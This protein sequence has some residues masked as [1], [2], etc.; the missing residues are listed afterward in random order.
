MTKL[1]DARRSLVRA[2]Q[3][4][5]ERIDKLEEERREIKTTIKSLE[6]ALRALDG[7]NAKSSRPRKSTTD[8]NSNEQAN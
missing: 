8:A 1:A 5:L 3:V 7:S 4:A 6:A 2:K